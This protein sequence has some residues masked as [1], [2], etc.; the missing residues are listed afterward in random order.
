[1]ASILDQDFP[2]EEE[3]DFNPAPEIGSDDEGD[4]KPEVDDDAEPVARN[5]RSRSRP[6]DVKDDAKDE[7]VGFGRDADDE[8]DGEANGEEEDE[9][10]EDE[11]EDEDDDLE[12]SRT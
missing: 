4:E 1:M 9:E 5:E 11:E 3:D 10:D 8:E 12:V 7:I 6:Q 2:D